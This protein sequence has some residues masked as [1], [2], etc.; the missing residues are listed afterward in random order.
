VAKTRKLAAISRINAA[1]T[2]SFCVSE[3]RFPA[4]GRHYARS[5][6]RPLAVLIE[7][8]QRKGLQQPFAIL[9]YQANVDS[10]A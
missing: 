2:T 6:S 5:R 9:L 3:S 1:Y 7:I 4:S 10:K 8:D